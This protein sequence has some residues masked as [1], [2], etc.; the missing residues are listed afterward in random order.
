MKIAVS[1][2][3]PGGLDA[4]VDPRF[5]RCPVYTLVEVEGK[6]IKKTTVIQNP[7]VQAISGAGTQAAQILANSSAT[8]VIAGNVGPN[9]Y[10]ALS[11]V[12]IQVIAGVA[13]M[14]VR[15]AVQRYIDGQLTSTTQPTGPT[16]MGTGAYGWSGM[17]MGRGMGRG[18]GM[19]MGRG[20]G[21]WGQAPSQMPP[22]TTRMPRKQETQALR[23]QAKMLEQQLNQIKKR[24]EE[25]S[26]K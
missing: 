18:M 26:K 22:P 4:Q 14:I 11:M 8:A 16:H 13:G 9:A 5:A 7:S 17:G 19:G 24:L 23:T 2:T 6:K 15:E 25:L 12:G 10:P 1:S 21:M 20:M 3:L